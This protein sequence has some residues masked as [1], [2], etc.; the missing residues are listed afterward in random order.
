M[1]KNQK[2]YFHSGADQGHPEELGEGESGGDE[3]EDYRKRILSLGLPR[4]SEDKLLR[5]LARLSKQPFASAE[6][7]VLRA[8][9]TPAWSCPGI[10]ARRTAATCCRA[11][12][13]DNDHYGLD[14]V[15]ERIVEYL[16]VRSLAPEQKGGVLAWWGRL[17]SVRQRGRQRGQG[18]RTAGCPAFPWAA[19][20]TRPR[21]G[22]PEDLFGAMPGRIMAGIR[23]RGA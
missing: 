1:A 14:K 3:L 2:E 20:M 7:A 17:A 12:G 21:S 19:S 13:L 23:Q 18:R 9:W 4:E 15:K 10:S 6:S 5:E 22:P 16:A 8:Y 11:P